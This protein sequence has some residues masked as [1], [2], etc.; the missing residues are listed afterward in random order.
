MPTQAK[1]ANSK[2]FANI[3]PRMFEQYIGYAN[4]CILLLFTVKLVL[5]NVN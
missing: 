3:Q 4:E 1:N 5:H 2:T